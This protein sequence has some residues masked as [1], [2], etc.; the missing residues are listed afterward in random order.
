VMVAGWSGAV[1]AKAFMRLL[2]DA[3]ANGGLAPVKET[4]RITSSG[5]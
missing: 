1:S 3:A 2:C 5:G 4:Q